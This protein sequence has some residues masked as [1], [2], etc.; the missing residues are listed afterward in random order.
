MKPE[1]MCT[2]MHSEL[3]EKIVKPLNVMALHD[4]LNSNIKIG[5]F[6]SSSLYSRLYIRLRENIKMNLK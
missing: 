6:M 4:N 3:L 5:R 2:K 1:N